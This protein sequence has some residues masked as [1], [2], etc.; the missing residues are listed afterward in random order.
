MKNLIEYLAT[1]K[2]YLYDL[3]PKQLEYE[4]Q[5]AISYCKEQGLEQ[6]F[7][8]QVEAMPDWLKLAE[9]AEVTFF[10]EEPLK[11]NPG[12]RRNAFVETGVFLRIF[13]QGKAP[14]IKVVI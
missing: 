1:A 5:R 13:E 2:H 8:L 6:K 10:I 3:S 11:Q 4:R 9:N 12:S 14:V 7:L